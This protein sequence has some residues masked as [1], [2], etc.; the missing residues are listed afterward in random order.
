MGGWLGCA[1]ARHQPH[2][3]RSLIVA[4]WGVDQSWKELGMPSAQDYF[5]LAHDAFA[6]NHLPNPV[7]DILADKELTCGISHCYD[8][9]WETDGARADLQSLS[10][11]LLL[12]C[13]TEDV[14]HDHLTA[15]ALETGIDLMSLP[16]D[17]LSAALSV[18]D[19]FDE[20]FAFWAKA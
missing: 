15:L 20:L 10:V 9:C 14:C 13:G 5:A 12:I 19:R 6:S 17:H 7:P 16:G 18:V 8:A 11:P 2:R 4:G 3:L 1:M